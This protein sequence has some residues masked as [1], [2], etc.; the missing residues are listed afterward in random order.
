[1]STPRRR[2]GLVLVDQAPAGNEGHDPDGNVDEEDPVPAERLGEDAAHQQA[3]G[4]SAHGHEDV[5]AHGLGP[6]G[7]VGELGDDDGEDD[8]RGEGRAQSLDETGPDEHPLGTGQPAHGRGH[9]E[10]GHP[11]HEH[12]LA[13]DEVTQPAGQQ[14]GAP[15]GDEVG[16][17][18]PRQAGLA[19][20]QLP[21]NGGQGD[22]HDGLVER[23]HEHGEAHDNQGDP[24]SPVACARCGCCQFH[25][26]PRLIRWTRRPISVTM[27]SQGSYNH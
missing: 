6:L 3:H 20:V 13:A 26:S 17:D 25:G 7:G 14:E 18:H 27:T 2:P 22:V 23:V 4:S 5:G 9:R 19:E 12:P 16:V 8:R 1:M 15:V 24:P 10:Q 11:G 21:L